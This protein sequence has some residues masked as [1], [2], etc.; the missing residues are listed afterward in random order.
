LNDLRYSLRSL[1]ANP[2]MTGAAVL[3]LALGIGANTAIFSG[4]NGIFLNPAPGVVR[5]SDLVEVYAKDNV[6]GD[7]EMSSPEFRDYRDRN[8]VLSGLLAYQ[9]F[10]SILTEGDGHERIWS[11]LVSANYFDVLGVAAAKGR[12]LGR[13]TIMMAV[14]RLRSSG[15][16]SG[17]GAS[18]GAATSLERRWASTAT[19]S[20]SWE[21][22]RRSFEGRSPAW[23]STRGSRWPTRTV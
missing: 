16:G 17:S 4:V 14:G 11:L 10:P 22:Q 1:F 15:M 2:G 19:R 6:L 9:Y 13:P 3:T 8:D 12:L 21:W 20:R 7:M 18:Q 23:C 5:A